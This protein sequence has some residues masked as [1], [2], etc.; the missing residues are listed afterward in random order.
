MSALRVAKAI[1]PHA[2]CWARHQKVW[3]SSGVDAM[4][5]TSCL[6]TAMVSLSITLAGLS[7]NLFAFCPP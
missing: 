5:L 2:I 7:V 1:V 6:A 4:Q 3:S